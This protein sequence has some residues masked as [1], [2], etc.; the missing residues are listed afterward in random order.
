MCKI[1]YYVWNV[2][3]TASILILTIIA[4]ERYIA[5][6]HPL[7]ARHLLTRRKLIVTQMVN[8]IIAISY[9]VPFLIFYDTVELQSFNVE[10]CYFDSDSVSGLKGLSVANLIVWYVIPLT[11]I[12]IIYYKIG[13][14]LWK[15]TVVSALRF[16][17]SSKKSS[18]GSFSTRSHC[19]TPIYTGSTK[20]QAE[21]SDE[22]NRS[23]NEQRD[24]SGSGNSES[25]KQED[26]V[27]FN[28]PVSFTFTH[29]GSPGTKSREELKCFINTSKRN[30]M[31]DD[32][33]NS[34]TDSTVSND[35]LS[36]VSHK[37][38]STIYRPE[39]PVGSRRVAK[40]RKEVVR[41]LTAIVIAFSICV[42]P[43]H[44]KVLNHHW[45]LF[46]LPHTVEVYISPCSFVVLYLNSA[47]NPILYA[48]LSKNFRK[49]L[50]ECL[51][52]FRQKQK[53]LSSPRQM[54]SR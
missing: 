18:V 29:G 46:A 25:N 24:N 16:Q 43:H 32:C 39:H 40:A 14:T 17:S 6:I 19:T 8:W 50:K 5:I 51:P 23:P 49:S 44:L 3:Y 54:R 34:P 31:K 1:Y 48:L 11:M 27:F 10:F 52:C 20:R 9:N 30:N 38:P 4:V 21:A 12:G 45:N 33:P 22:L 26:N 28:G 35:Q 42:L 37:K 7:K 53:Q 41:L 13:R 47:L 36:G 2:S 15:T